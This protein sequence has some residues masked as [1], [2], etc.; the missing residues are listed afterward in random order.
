MTSNIR[1]APLP[2]R[3]VEERC[4]G[5]K[6]RER[7]AHRSREFIESMLD[8]VK[9]RRV[10]PRE[11]PRWNKAAKAKDEEAGRTRRVRRIGGIRQ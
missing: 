10:I 3:M 8:T 5:L 4:D 2:M 7:D 1:Y 9:R 11:I 6:E